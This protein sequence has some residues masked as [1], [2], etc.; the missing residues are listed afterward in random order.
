M[1]PGHVFVSHTS[2]VAGYPADRSFVQAALDAVSRAGMVP[3]DM[4]YLP[5]QDGSPAEV[6]RDRVRQCEIY[7]GVVGLRYGSLVPGERVSYTELEFIEAGRAGRP[8]LVFLLEETACPPASVDRD[9]TAIMDFRSRLAQA[10]LVIR[11]CANG[12]ELELEIFHALS[13]LNRTPP[14]EMTTE[15]LSLRNVPSRNAD[16]TGREEILQQLHAGLAQDG[17]ALVTAQAL[18]GLGGVGKTQV[19]LEYAHRYRAEYDLVWWIPAEHVQGISLSLAELADRLGLR[20]SGNSGQDAMLALEYIRRDKETRWLLIFDNADNPRDSEP[21]LPDGNGHVIITSRDHTWTH[22]A[23]PVE[24]TV[25][26]RPESITH[27]VQHVRGLSSH[28]A[29]SISAAVGDLPLAIEQAAAWLSETGMPV[30]LY[31]QQMEDRITQALSLN[32]AFGYATP[33]AAAWD[34]SFERLRNESP[35]AIHLLRIL[36]F[37]SPQAI[38]MTLVYSEE[39]RML[40]LPYNETLG[41]KLAVGRLVGEISRLALARVDHSRKSLQMHRLVQAAI[42]T[43]LTEEQQDRFKHHVHEVLAG[44][45]LQQDEI[46]D[47]ENWDTYSLI[48]PHLKTSQAEYCSSPPTRQLMLDWVRYQWRRGQFKSSLETAE[49]LK[50]T[51]TEILGPDHPQTLQ[52]N[53]HTGNVLRS[54]GRFAEA[55]ELDQYTLQRQQVTLGSHHLDVLRTTGSLGADLLCLGEPQLAERTDRDAYEKLQAGFGDEY[56]RTLSAAHNLAAALNY[57][58]SP[59][60]ALRLEQETLGTR[61]RVLGDSHIYTL[62]SMAIEAWYLRETGAFSESAEV[63]ARIYEEFCDVFGNEFPET[64]NTGNS[65][66]ISLRKIGEI[67]EAIS[68]TT[69]L[70]DRARKHYGDTSPHTLSCTL[71]LANALLAQ[72]EVTEAEKLIRQVGQIYRERVGPGHPDTLTADNNLAICLRL[73]AKSREGLALAQQTLAA[74]SERLGVE[75]PAALS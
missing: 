65:L 59:F 28:D 5:A 38:A 35:A 62:D 25:F 63:L 4:R 23:Q 51:W 43:Q 26:S 15:A 10:G 32:K 50:G 66:T 12:H 39:M 33:V 40:L 14:T 37:F 75:H 71:S 11:S 52:L 44:I 69:K 46:D 55:R 53:F 22:H 7:V 57:A 56:P 1:N 48:W 34:M 60:A 18:Y 27:L 31:L 16:F 36:A 58:G 54:L 8:R 74:M 24:L 30:D 29:E 42:R 67:D 19:A 49:T 2:D 3:V 13:A 70:R 41:N 61:K 73:Q 6:C 72:R 17:T 47:P 45:Q 64:L 9:G 20:V 21:F 68:K